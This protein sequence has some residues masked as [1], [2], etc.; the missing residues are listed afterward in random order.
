MNISFIGLGIMGSRMAC[1]LLKHENS[2]L[3]VFNRSMKPADK[4]AESGAFKADSAEDAVSGSDVVFTMLSDPE[5]VANLAFKDKGF[6]YSMKKNAVWINC[7]TVNPSFA[8]ECAM[9]SAEHDIKFIDAPVAGSLKPAE[10]GE[11]T[12]LVGG[13][14]KDIEFV[15]PLLELMGK[16]I[17]YLGDAGQGSAFK[18]LVNSLLAQSMAIYSETALLGEKLGFSR[19]FLMDVLPELPVT[20]PFFKGKTSMIK[21]GEYETEFPLELML[22]D[23]H[24]LDITAYEKNH[25]LYLGSAVKQLYAGAKSKGMA[26]KDFSSIFSFLENS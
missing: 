5:T 14:E 9:R 11:L 20:A 26:R 22:K 6:V 15:K 1:N 21:N 24:L 7:S 8:R 2:K 3:T 23:L 10:N 25:P 18:M 12:F 4:L 16:K 17:L 13:E 19:D